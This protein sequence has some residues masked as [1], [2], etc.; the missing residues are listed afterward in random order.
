MV[1]TLWIPAFA[2]MTWNKA[3]VWAS[4]R[5]QAR[6]A[7]DKSP[8]PLWERA[9]VRVTRA[10][11]FAGGT[12]ALPG[13]QTYP[14]KPVKEKESAVWDLYLISGSEHGGNH[15]DSRFRGND[16]AII[17]NN[18]AIIASLRPLRLCA[19]ASNSLCQHANVSA[20]RA[21]GR[22]ARAPIRKPTH[23][24]P[25]A[26]RTACRLP[27]A[28]RSPAGRGGAGRCALAIRGGAI[29]LFR[30]GCPTAERPARASF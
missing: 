28:P 8:F 25:A 17:G 15:L 7:S 27:T 9:R 18:S 4:D 19:F 6:I 22:D 1:A 3:L 16:G 21:S 11:A 26:P 13:L 14:Y 29:W 24:T 2:G 10:S 30:R 23:P 12:P 20:P 5:N